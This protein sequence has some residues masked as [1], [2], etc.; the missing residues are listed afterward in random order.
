[1]G[2]IGQRV[3]ALALLNMQHRR[4]VLLHICIYGIFEVEVGGQARTEDLLR[5]RFSCS[6]THA[7]S[8]ARCKG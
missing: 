5:L 7:L 2:Q 4:H 1:M 6:E 8:M 3:L